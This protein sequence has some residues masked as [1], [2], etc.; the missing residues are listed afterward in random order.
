MNPS[1]IRRLRTLELGVHLGQLLGFGL[2]RLGLYGRLGLRR[3]LGSLRL[4]GR[5]LR[6]LR[7]GPAMCW[8]RSPISTST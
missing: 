5:S 3:A 7:S 2:Q 6:A 1:E 8:A 4:G